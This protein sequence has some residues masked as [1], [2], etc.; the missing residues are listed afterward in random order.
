MRCK[1]LTTIRLPYKLQWKTRAA[2]NPLCPP[3][4]T[5]TYTAHAAHGALSSTEACWHWTPQGVTRSTSSTA[6]CMLA[7]SLAVALSLAPQAILSFLGCAINPIFPE[8]K[9]EQSRPRRPSA[10]LNSARP[11]LYRLQCGRFNKGEVPCSGLAAR[12]AEASHLKQPS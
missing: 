4:L 11:T 5:E 2:F 8:S 7:L 10:R 9:L 1:G 12:I 3:S 6:S